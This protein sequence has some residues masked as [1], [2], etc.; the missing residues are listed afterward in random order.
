MN[1]I[2][3]VGRSGSGKTCYFYA[4]MNA[5]TRGRHG[6]ALCLK[7]RNDF[8]MINQG[9][10]RLKNSRLPL[11]ERWPKATNTVETFD[12]ELT[13]C[14][15]PIA[16]FQW[17]DY[18]G[19]LL[20]VSSAKFIEILK[21]TSC[22]LV[23]VDGGLMQGGEE[24]IGDIIGDIKIDCGLELNNAL[25]QAADVNGG[26]PPVC[27]V[28][29]KYDLV[30]PALSTAK[31]QERIVKGVFGSLFRAG[32][33]ADIECTVCPVSLGREIALGGKLEPK[34]IEMPMFYAN[35][36]LLMQEL[37]DV[38]ASAKADAD[39]RDKAVAAWNNSGVIGRLL[40]PR[41]RPVTEEEK[42]AIS[43][44]LDKKK[45]VL[46]GVIKE[47]NGM[48]RFVNGKETPWPQPQ[49]STPRPDGS[50]DGR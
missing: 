26:L 35:Y 13:Y 46:D 15:R 32:L 11:K 20:S 2:T 28:I 36:I 38:V 3:I 42:K 4:M 25:L 5:L 7:N 14:T 23:C 27:V 19:E 29:T 48:H 24:D 44:M 31:C 41:P 43:E 21:D 40:T 17:T 8:L 37:R 12:M 33:K 10:K 22:L 6:F 34:N 45:G 30:S 50:T 16:Q 9:M 1:K 39:L 47:F 49:P 18:P